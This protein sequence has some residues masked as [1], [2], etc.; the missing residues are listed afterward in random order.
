MRTLRTPDDRFIDLP[1]YD[2]EPHYAEIADSEGGTLRVHYLREG[3]LRPRSCSSCT[4]SRPGRTCT[5]R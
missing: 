5:A 2:F 4:A 1:G 3:T